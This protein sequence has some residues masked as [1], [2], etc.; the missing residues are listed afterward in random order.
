MKNDTHLAGQVS[1]EERGIHQGSYQDCLE[2]GCYLPA[3]QPDPVPNESGSIQQL[4]IADMAKREKVGIAR[5]GTPLQVG[6]GRDM[7]RDAYEEALDLAVYLRGL[8]EERR[9]GTV[10]APERAAWQRAR[11]EGSSQELMGDAPFEGARRGQDP[12]R[13]GLSGHLGNLEQ[14]RGPDCSD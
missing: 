4:V 8:I 3:E 10:I 1:G 14:R 11:W 7:L 6:N 13:A 5:Y 2:P 9:L 12:G